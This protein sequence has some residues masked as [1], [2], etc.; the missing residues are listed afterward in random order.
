MSYQERE[1]RARRR[2]R[3]VMSILS[4]LILVTLLGGYFYIRATQ[5]QTGKLAVLA[6]SQVTIGVNETSAPEEEPSATEP[7]PH[8]T[9]RPA[10]SGR[11]PG[12]VISSQVLGESSV[13]LA[14]SP[15]PQPAA[16]ATSAPRTGVSIGTSPLEP[17]GGGGAGGGGG[18]APTPTRT[19]APPGVTVTPTTPGSP[20]PSATP[21]PSTTPRPTRTAGPPTPTPVT[22]EARPIG[23]NSHLSIPGFAAPGAYTTG[24]VI[25]SN[26][27]EVA[28]NYSLS[29]STSGSGD[30]ARALR[31]RIYLRVGTSCNY[32]GPP[33]SPSGDFLP[34]ASDQVGTVLYDG[35]FATGNRFGDPTVE[36]APGDRFLDVGE[37]EVLCMEVFFPWPAGNQYQGQSVNATM[38]FTAKSPE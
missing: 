37:S 1:L 11:A 5:E 21:E 30:F 6:T 14:A 10:A 24:G 34:L 22:E 18:G 31:L 9:P 26:I 4:L 28:F 8:P 20:G 16:T 32:P 13:P 3:V 17:P 27:G 29:F 7:S 2:E 35:D 23:A 25:V 12:P 15:S 36:I 38:I 19:S 33:P